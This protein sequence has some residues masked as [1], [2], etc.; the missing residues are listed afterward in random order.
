MHKKRKR[1]AYIRIISL[2]FIIILMAGIYKINSVF[3]PYF[4][5]RLT[6]DNIKS[7]DSEYQN[8]LPLDFEELY[9]PHAILIRLNDHK[10]I[11]KNND[12]EKIYPASLT[13]IMTAIVAIE[14]I[15]NLE[16]MIILPEKLFTDL[17][18]AN[19][20]MA[21]F[22]PGEEVTALDLLYGTLLPSGAD[23]SLG[24]AI[25]ISGSESEFVKLMNK[26]AK[27]LGMEDTHFVNVTG[28]HDGNHYT[29]VKDIAMLLQYALKNETF[30]NIF[31]T[32]RHSTDF[33]NLHPGGITFYST[34]FKKTNTYEF[35]GGKIIGGKTGYT[36]ES[37]LCL[38]SLAEKGKYEYIL[39]TAGAKG[40]QY[41]EQFH[42]MDAFTVYENFVK[43]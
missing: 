24:L 11:Y 27:E 15:P 43:D 26:K 37:G 40:N 10:V 1:V 38:A 41:T 20:T 33:T 21:G 29:T 13:K 19:A 36:D 8:T 32:A 16:E 35:D 9:S 25:R 17:Y 3:W 42:V 28:L 39:V 31:T 18:I 7:L 6:R 12:D 14:N 4:I 5:N 2:L 23:A 34:L 22:L 30:R